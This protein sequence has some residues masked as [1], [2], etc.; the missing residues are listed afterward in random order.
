MTVGIVGSLAVCTVLYLAVAAIVTGMAP[1]SEI[2][3][4][5]PVAQAFRRHGLD[6]AG[7]LISAGAIAGLSSV[8]LVLLL[9]QSRIFFSM[10]RDG[11]L[12]ELFSAV[13]PRFGTPHVSTIGVGLIVAVIAG[14]VPLKEL[15]EL[16]NIGTLFAFVIVSIGILVLRRTEPERRRPFRTPWVPVVPICA[17]AGSF[18]LM[19][20]LPLATWIRFLVWLVLGLAIYFG[21]SRRHSRVSVASGAAR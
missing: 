12:P 17:A 1:L 13:H 4:S 16:A 3:T 19:A 5:A 11:L 18:Y 2:D 6:F 14:F 15:A 9:G 10:S 7:G 20:A 21:Y 8:L